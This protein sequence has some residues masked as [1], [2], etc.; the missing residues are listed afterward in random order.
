MRYHFQKQALG[1]EHQTTSWLLVP[2]TLFLQTS[3]SLVYMSDELI[4]PLPLNLEQ[5]PPFKLINI[6]KIQFHI[7]NF[8][9]GSYFLK[10][11]ITI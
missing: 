9:L 2:Q 5:C 6:L 10:M 11:C 3:V 4:I 8:I 1:T 7:W